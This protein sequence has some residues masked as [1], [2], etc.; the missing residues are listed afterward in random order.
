MFE[1]GD[2]VIDSSNGICKIENQVH[3]DMDGIDENQVF[4]MVVPVE[5]KNAREYI[6]VEKINEKLR[7][8]MNKDQA[9]KLMD[10]IP[11]LEELCVSNEKQREK[12]YKD[13]VL[14]ND[15][16]QLIRVIK[17]IYIRR[18]HRAAAGKKNT[19]IDERYLK[20]AEN[21]LYHELAFAIGKTPSEIPDLIAKRLSKLQV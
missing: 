16:V 7:R 6:P 21:S 19:V 13:A 12:I 1:V 20:I 14:S 15:P 18:E 2:Y 11:D 17:T 9:I 3:L 10:E 8:V 5:E 4:F